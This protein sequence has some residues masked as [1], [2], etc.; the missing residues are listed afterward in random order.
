MGNTEASQ[1][2][3][4]RGR[5][6]ISSDGKVLDTKGGSGLSTPTPGG[7]ARLSTGESLHRVVYTLFKGEIPNKRA[8]NH[9]DGDKL[10]NHIDNL[11]AV[12]YRENSRHAANVL[13]VGNC[14]V[15]RK[16]TESEVSDIV[17]ALR[18]TFEPMRRIAK[19]YN[20]SP[21]AIQMINSGVNYSRLTL[22]SCNDYPIRSKS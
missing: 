7:Y 21:N 6:Y 12:T 20:V 11:E 18:D 13:N 14:E 10:N 22:G 17:K 4:Y 9:I 1:S 2:V 15:V 16:L 19:R 5:F 3:L 8:I